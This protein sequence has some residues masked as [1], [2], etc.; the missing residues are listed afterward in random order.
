MTAVYIIIGI[1]ALALLFV[2]A[3]YNGLVRLRNQMENA[4]AQ[5]NVQ[6][7][8]RHNL[9]PNLVNTVKGYAAH[10][11]ETLE[12]VTNARKTWPRAQSAKAWEL[13]P[14]PKGYSV[15]PCPGCWWWLKAI[16]I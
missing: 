12:A 8:R 16:P 6:L 7:K 15:G 5:I 4:W 10:E 14:R 11:R 13:N 1:V 3:T 9:I 2:V